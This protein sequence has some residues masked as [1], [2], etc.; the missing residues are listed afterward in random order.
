MAEVV[1]IISDFP[2][3]I[4]TRDLQ[5]EYE[6]RGFGSGSSAAA[7]AKRAVKNEMLAAEIQ[8]L[9]RGSTTYV[10]YPKGQAEG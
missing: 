4:R 2:D 10:F 5:A 1:E 6:R 7:S 9:E 3:G 8:P